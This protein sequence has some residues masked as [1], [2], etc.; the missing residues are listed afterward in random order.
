ML[1]FI[2]YVLNTSFP[3]KFTHYF[4]LYAMMHI[5][6]LFAFPRRVRYNGQSK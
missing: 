2:L 4:F 3:N 6:Y 5:I 1:I